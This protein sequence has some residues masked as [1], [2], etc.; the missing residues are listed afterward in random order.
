MLQK[1]VVQK[2]FHTL[3]LSCGGVDA[4]VLE[5]CAKLEKRV[6]IEA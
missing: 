1:Y 2:Y 4:P 5:N 3:R 6:L